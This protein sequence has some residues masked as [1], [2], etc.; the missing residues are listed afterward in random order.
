ML[1]GLA[2]ERE[3]RITIDDLDVGFRVVQE[4][5]IRACG[6]FDQRVDFVEPVGVAGLAV[7]CNR[8]RTQAYRAYFSWRCVALQGSSDSGLAA[9]V[10]CGL[11]RSERAAGPVSEGLAAMYRHSVQKLADVAAF[12]DLQG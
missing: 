12:A 10:G 2:C 8:A 5:E 6:G 3:A 1:I 11:G 9:V 4:C 7:G